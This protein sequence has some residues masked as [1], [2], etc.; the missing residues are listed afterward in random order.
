MLKVIGQGHQGKLL[1]QI[2]MDFVIANYPTWLI[3]SSWNFVH[4]KNLIWRCAYYWDIPIH[5][6]LSLFFETIHHALGHHNS[7]HML[8]EM[9]VKLSILQDP[10]MKMCTLAPYPSPL[11]DGSSRKIVICKVIVQRSQGQLLGE[12]ICHALRCPCFIYIS[13]VNNL[14]QGARKPQR[15]SIMY[16]AQCN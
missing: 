2:I 13:L 7:S 10:N 3:R 12:G 4:C 16:N 11:S 8:N 6:G 1:R 14:P 15:F 9:F 5:W